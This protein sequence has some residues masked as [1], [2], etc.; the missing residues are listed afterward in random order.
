MIQSV[1]LTIVLV[2]GILI[3][4]VC[5]YGVF[6]PARLMDFVLRV[7]NQPGGL[8]TAVLV[9]VL[10]GLNLIAASG[11]SNFPL[12]FR[13]LGCIAL[14]VAIVILLGGRQLVQKMIDWGLKRPQ[15]MLR[16]WLGAGFAFGI[17]LIWGSL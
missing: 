1:A 7:W 15:A 16:G 3:A 5:I 13:V 8:M 2:F 14:V 9:R 4:A 12:A 11:V 10:L 6:A 17:F